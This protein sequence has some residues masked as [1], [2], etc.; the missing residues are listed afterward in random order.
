MAGDPLLEPPGESTDQG[1]GK[2]LIREWGNRAVLPG[3]GPA[4]GPGATS[5]SSASTDRGNIICQIN[6]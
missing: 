1:T 5:T 3:P 2:A 4:L 6:K